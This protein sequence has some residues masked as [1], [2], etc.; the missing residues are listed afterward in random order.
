M[1]PRNPHF[2]GADVVIGTEGRVAAPQRPGVRDP[3]G[4]QRAGHVHEGSPG[5]WEAPPPPRHLPAGGYRV[6]NSRP[7]AGA[8]GGHGNETRVRPWYRQAKVTKRGGTG[9]RESERLILPMTRG[10]RPEG[11]R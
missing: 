1:E 10:N 9:G 4:G 7:A 8:P 2:A 6:T 5:T 3:A 11:P